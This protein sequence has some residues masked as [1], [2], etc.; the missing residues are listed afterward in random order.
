MQIISRLNNR[1]V[2][3]DAFGEKYLVETY[4]DIDGKDKF[5]LN[6]TVFEVDGWRVVEAL[7]QPK[8]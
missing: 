6:G 5:E 1:L 8:Q 7:W 4:W 3:Q 2:I